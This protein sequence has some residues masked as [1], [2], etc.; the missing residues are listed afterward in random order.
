M[1]EITKRHQAMNA[2]M[3]AFKQHFRWQYAQVEHLLIALE[4][5]TRIP[6]ARL[7]VQEQAPAARALTAFETSPDFVMDDLLTE[8]NRA[9]SYDIAQVY[10]LIGVSTFYSK[11]SDTSKEYSKRASE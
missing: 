9:R 8:E 11:S 10:Q 2:V 3:S 4:R 1:R 5:K 6:W 7:N